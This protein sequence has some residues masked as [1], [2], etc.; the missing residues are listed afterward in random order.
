M[1]PYKPTNW[2][3]ALALKRTRFNSEHCPDCG[4]K[5]LSPFRVTT[6]DVICK[7]C[8]AVIPVRRRV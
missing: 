6:R 2:I 7:K 5:S 4:S 3:R 8:K 1:T